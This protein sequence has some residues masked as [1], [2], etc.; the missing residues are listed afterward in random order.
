[1]PSACAFACGLPVVTTDAGGI[2]FIVRH[3]VNGLMVP[4]NND[5]A[6]AAFVREVARDVLG[7]ANVIDAEPSMGGEDFSAYQE[8][9]PGCYFFIGSAPPKGEVFPHHH[10]R[11]NPDEDVLETAVAV[12]TEAARRSPSGSRPSWATARSRASRRP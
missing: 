9:A 1:M 10:P 6:M 8:L 11:F 5:A 2:P 7:K 3:D 12:L 4:R